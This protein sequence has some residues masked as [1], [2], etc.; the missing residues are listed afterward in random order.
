MSFLLYTAAFS[1]YQDRDGKRI[2]ITVTGGNRV[3]F[4]KKDIE[5]VEFFFIPGSWFYLTQDTYKVC[6]TVRSKPIAFYF[7]SSKIKV[8]NSCYTEF[9]KLLE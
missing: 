2:E 7:D 1:L 5:M 4:L 9:S 3:S 6:V 8:A